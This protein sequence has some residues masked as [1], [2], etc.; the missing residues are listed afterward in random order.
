LVGQKLIEPLVPSTSSQGTLLDDANQKQR[1]GSPT[2]QKGLMP[3]PKG[4][5]VTEWIASLLC[6]GRIN[7]RGPVAGT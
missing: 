7:F 4:N 6:V 5:E 1:L 2:D 3:L